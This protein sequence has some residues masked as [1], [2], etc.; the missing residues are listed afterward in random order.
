[1]V[2]PPTPDNE[3]ERL[4]VLRSL[5]LLD[6]SPDPILDEFARLAAAIS[7]API[8]LVSLVDEHRQWFAARVG[9]AVTET[10]RRVSFCA[11]AINSPSE[12]FW[13]DDARV[14][15][16]FADNPLVV[17]HP[18]VRFYAGA[19]LVVAGSPIGTLC[20]IDTLPR[21]CDPLLVE[22][23]ASLAH[24]LADR[25]DSGHRNE[26]TRK[27][28]E[29]TA[30][31]VIECDDHGVITKWG[32]GAERLLGFSEAESVGRPV[33]IFV[34]PEFHAAH[35]A[36]M[37][38]WRSTKEGRLGRRI[39]VPAIRKDGSSIELELAMSVSRSQKGPLIT[40]SIRDIS[41]RKA[42]AASLM[43][44]KAE[45]E[46]ANVAKSAF[47]A[48]MSH[49]IRTPLNGVVGVVG[50]LASTPLSARQEELTG[51]IRSS[52]EQLQRILG[53][54]LDLA[55]IESGHFTISEEQFG[56]AEQVLAIADLS[57]LK[58]EEKGL[59]FQA[60]IDITPG[61]RVIGDPMRLKQVLGNLLSNAVKF[62][63]RGY[64]RLTVTSSPGRYRFEVADSGIGFEQEQHARLFDPFYQA[65]G[66]VTRRYGG[67]GLGLSICRN[68]V[69]AMG[70]EI[71]CIGCTG[72]GA[73]F[74][75]EL[76]LPVAEVVENP[77][78]EE[79]SQTD[80]A[81]AVLV[82][83]DNPTNRRVAELILLSV[84]A[85]V[86]QA[87][88]GAAAFDA[89]RRTNF[90]IILMDLMM[91]VMDGLASIRLIRSHEQERGWPRTPIAVLSANSMPEHVE[92]SLAAGADL[93]LAKPITAPGLLQ[94]VSALVGS[95]PKT[96][97]FACE[98][99]SHVNAVRLRF[100]R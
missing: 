96:E 75:V 58:A 33:T 8:A 90:D 79:V 17:G 83:D 59:N 99:A 11:H 34:P 39:E 57:R 36:G 18:D 48:N 29:I 95:K 93:H 89:A 6:Q 81:L 68:L 25:L 47:L 86:T 69:E 70:G 44:A 52:S 97:S 98:E 23:L 63:E 4:D 35:D 45:A 64:V 74:W 85:T 9:L 50:L 7:G 10:P 19:P 51:I 26:A 66:S 28:L 5:E 16:R 84:G 43:A 37:A 15:G 91:P 12:V 49:E 61:Q 40:S 22:T 94:A 41:E 71:G 55:R 76:P 78:R 27:A 32:A 54:V 20:V 60:V 62:T 38:R 2:E 3:T 87:E 65:D 92:A 88:D 13:V 100:A 77:D 82:V 72:Q 67:S 30:D 21:N 53:D 56:L 31:A 80:A 46:A 14:D 1:M 24:L 73:T 42:Y